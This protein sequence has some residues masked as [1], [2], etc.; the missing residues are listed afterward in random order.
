MY[1]TVEELKKQLNV[2]YSDDDEYMSRLL[3][4]AEAAVQNDIRRPLSE[5][6]DMAQDVWGRT[7]PA[8][9]RHAILL[10]ATNLYS[11]REPVAFATPQP[12]PY[13]LQYLLQP[14]IKY[15]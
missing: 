12:V 5:L 2:D 7:I 14:Y 13:T 3:D 4:V 10:I 15:T 11:N 1:V 9:L 6:E 8:P